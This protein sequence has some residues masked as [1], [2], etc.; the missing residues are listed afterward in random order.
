MKLKQPSTTSVLVCAGCGWTAPSPEELRYPFRCP[1]AGRGDIDHVVTRK[2][3][4][5]KVEWSRGEDPNPFIRHREL[6]HSWHLARRRGLSDHAYVA[7]VRELDTAI[8]RVDGR[9][10]GF[11]AMPFGNHAALNERLGLELWVKDET[12]NVAG[13][14]KARHLMAILLYLQVV[15][16]RER[17]PLA[18]ASC[19]NAALAAATLARAVERALTV[20]VP[21]DAA[22]AVLA[23]LR[24][25]GAQVETCPR[26]PGVVGDPCLALFRDAVAGGALFG[27]FW[28]SVLVSF[29]SSLGA[30]LA[31]LLSRF[32]L[33]EFVER[34]FPFA[35]E[36]VNAGIRSDGAYYLFGL[37]LVPVFPFFVINLVMG[38][39]R[40]PLQTFY[41]VSQASMLP[42]TLIYVN[43]G[44]QLAAI[45]SARDIVSPGLAL[46]LALL[47]LFPWLAKR[48]TN[49]IMA[50]H[51]SRA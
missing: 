25:L 34:K 35:V 12:G 18:I 38:L 1:R 10:S 19:G 2:L 26:A 14:H 24:T 41:W 36:R 50:W 33:R 8:A 48:I 43:A 9:G 27:V 51:R 16:R 5:F 21:P 37:R 46:S 6:L 40:L 17:P 7:L 15:E 39:T 45:R 3:D 4:T 44:T 11:R 23:R 22:P 49:A 32:L 42:G 47:G 30:V 13:S 28:G 29:A 31:C 20:F